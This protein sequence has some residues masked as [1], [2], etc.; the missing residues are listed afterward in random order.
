MEFWKS[1]F[2]NNPS[3]NW[4]FAPEN[5]RLEFPFGAKGLVSEAKW[6]LVSV[7]FCLKQVFFPYI[8]IFFPLTSPLRHQLPGEFR[9][10]RAGDMKKPRLMGVVIAID[11]WKRW[12]KF[13][14]NVG[15][16]ILIKW[17]WLVSTIIICFTSSHSYLHP[18]A[19]PLN[20]ISHC[21]TLSVALGQKSIVF[22]GTICLGVVF[23]KR[24]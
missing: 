1:L 19:I 6:L 8:P 13:I 14:W 23:H 20:K 4:H 5:Q 15:W 16:L 21:P 22:W 24:I 10:V 7:S 17:F 9:R 18:F 11:T 3:W 2:P 12:Y